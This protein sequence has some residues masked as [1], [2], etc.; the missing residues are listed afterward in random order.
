MNI[1]HT[2][3]LFT[4]TWFMLCEFYLNGKKEEEE[5]ASGGNRVP[6]A[7]DAGT[8]LRGD[9]ASHIQRTLLSCV[10]PKLGLR[11]E[12][13]CPR[14]SWVSTQC[15]HQALLLPVPSASHAWRQCVSDGNVPSQRSPAAPS[16]ELPWQLLNL[17]QE[18]A[19]SP[20][21]LA[22]KGPRTSV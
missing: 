18:S 15:L 10:R 17:P 20:G 9:S 21:D 13:E 5:N 4:C 19:A 16:T 22:G 6:W 14:K 12:A 7:E 2:T 1:L 11:K 8:K 3:E